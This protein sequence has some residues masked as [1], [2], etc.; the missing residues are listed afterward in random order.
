MITLGIS[1]SSGKPSA[2]V[3]MPRF[4]REQVVSFC[5][6]PRHGKSHSE[7]LMH[8]IENALSLAGVEKT[9][10]DRIAVDIGPGSFT[11]VRI[12]VSCA[13]AMAFALGIPV[14]PVCSLA[15]L[16]AEVSPYGPAAALI[17]CRNGNCYAAAYHG[18]EEALAPC[19][20]VTEEVVR[21]LPEGAAITGDCFEPKTYPDA[22]LVLTAA[23]K[24]RITPVEQA[25][26]MYLRPS[27]AER[28]KASSD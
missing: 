9:E 21:N 28:M 24:G 25:V 13:N 1:T 19:A 3:L 2:A 6:E 22:R 23:A 27:Q 10:I 26:P 15:A 11:G 4:G 20:A 16:T 14:V 12:G 8:L 17:D 7:V 5:T 18:G